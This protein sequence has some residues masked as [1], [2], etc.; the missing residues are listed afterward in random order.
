MFLHAWKMDFPHP[1]RE[2][3][4]ALEAPL[5]DALV[6]FLKTLSTEEKQDYGQKI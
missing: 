3:R 4:L 5:P 6:E 2:E 1:T